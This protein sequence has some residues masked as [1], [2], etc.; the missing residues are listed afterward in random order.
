M[1]NKYEIINEVMCCNGIKCELEFGNQ[2]QIKVLRA[3]E[4]MMKELNGIGLDIEPRYEIKFRFRC[5]CGI[6]LSHE[7]DIDTEDYVEDFEP[8]KKCTCRKCN[9][10]YSFHT[11]GQDTRYHV[12]FIGY[13][14]E[15]DYE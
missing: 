2:E 6:H 7:E 12:L 5:I 10:Q 4:L 9:R 3:H 8:N 15:D 14:K 11:G 1:S 13:R